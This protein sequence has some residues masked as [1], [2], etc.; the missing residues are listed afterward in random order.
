VLYFS[1]I[2]QR[3][4]CIAGRHLQIVKNCRPVQLGEFAQGGSFDV[5]PALHALTL[6]EGLGIFAFEV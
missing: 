6:K 3:L 2:F 5:H 1:I 4:K